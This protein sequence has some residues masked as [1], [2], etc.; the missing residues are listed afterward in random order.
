[1]VFELRKGDE[2]RP[3][4]I[5]FLGCVLRLIIV[6][7][8]STMQQPSMRCSMHLSSTNHRH[9]KI[10]DDPPYDYH[11]EKYLKIIKKTKQ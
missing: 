7:M 2:S 8:Q 10:K 6:N 1:M 4:L 11:T 5:R 3:Y 9:D